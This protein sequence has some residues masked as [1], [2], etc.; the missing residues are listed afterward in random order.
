MF[1]YSSEFYFHRGLKIKLDF[2]I[3]R[4]YLWHVYRCPYET[5]GQMIPMYGAHVSVTLPLHGNEIV[6]KSKKYAGQDVDLWY[7]GY[8]KI[9]GRLKYNGKQHKNYWMPM[10]CPR[11]E[12]IKNELGIV[13][14]NFLGFHCTISNNKNFIKQ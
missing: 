2:D 10:E 14:N 11:A 8:I 1:K 6:E 3:L 13:E 4:Y 9:G 12:E 7:N 5:L